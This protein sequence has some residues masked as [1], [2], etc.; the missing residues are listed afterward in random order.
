MNYKKTVRKLHDTGWKNS[1][2]TSADVSTIGC[3]F[4]VSM[5][6][7]FFVEDLYIY[8]MLPRPYL[9]HFDGRPEDKLIKQKWVLNL[10]N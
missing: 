1:Y 8:Q 6:P 2:H 9:T 7:Q 3:G 10:E 5:Y 4:G